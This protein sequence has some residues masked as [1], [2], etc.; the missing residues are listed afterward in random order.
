LPVFPYP[1]RRATI[2]LIALTRILRE[3]IV[4]Q[5]FI[6]LADLASTPNKPGKL[7][8]SPAT[9]WRWV[10][11]GKFPKPFKLGQSVTVWDV[12]CVESFIAQ[13]SAGTGE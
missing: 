3:H 6:R 10:R 11:E 2:N 12:G 5:K 9:V 1:D 13:R 7:P 4:A 8:V